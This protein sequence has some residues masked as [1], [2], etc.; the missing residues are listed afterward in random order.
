MN[1]SNGPCTIYNRDLESTIHLFYEFTKITP[2]W[3]YLE[4]ELQKITQDK[5]IS[6][7]V[8]HVLLGETTNNGHF[9]VCN[10]IILEAKWP[11]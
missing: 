3:T 6:L 2:M 1:K 4:F 9:K 8:E 7:K 11:I 5:T 10:F